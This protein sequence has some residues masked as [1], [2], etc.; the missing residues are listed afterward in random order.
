[1]FIAM[2]PPKHDIQ[3]KTVSPI[4]SPVNLAK[5]EGLI[6]ERVLHDPRQPA[7]RRALRLGR[8]GLDRTDHPDAGHP[9]RLPLGRAPQ[10][11][12][13]VRRRHRLAGKRPSSRARTPAEAELLECLGYFT[14]LWNERVNAEPP[15]GD[16]ISMLAQGEATKNMPPMEYLGNIILLIVGGND[17]TRNSMTGSVSGPEPRTPTSKPSCGPIPS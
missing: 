12:P 10:A 7:D 1:M 16:L 3:R 8:Q 2:D 17:T 14:N 11:D 9:V 15:G 13:L 5:L 6:R 4:V